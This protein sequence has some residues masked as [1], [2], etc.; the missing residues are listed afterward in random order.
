MSST[1]LVPPDRWQ[2][3]TQKSRRRPR[4]SPRRLPPE[5][6]DRI[7]DFCHNDKAT[8]SNCALT[9]SSWLAASRLHLFHTVTTT[10][11]HQG[12]SR[13]IQLASI[14]H[15]R[16][17][18][19]PHK[20]SPSVIPY[21]K[22][23]KIDSLVDPG[24]AARLVDAVNLACAIRLFCN[25][26]RLPDPSVHATLRR[27]LRQKEPPSLWPFSLLNDIVTHINLS[28]VTFGHPSHIWTFLSS[29]PRLQY[30]ELEGIGFANSEESRTPVERT[31]DGVPLST[32]R[33]TTASM[34]F[35]IDSLID[36]KSVV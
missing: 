28:N 27:S 3:I 34:G 24:G 25:L 36:R 5:L 15:K 29:F 11:A 31:F 4:L 20:G 2:R 30:L 19:H 13:A 22:T 26:E 33:M 18:A 1:R 8:L 7:I 35:I 16:R 6:T 9:H 12:R 10:R 14:V 21:I 32:I 17:F 23:V